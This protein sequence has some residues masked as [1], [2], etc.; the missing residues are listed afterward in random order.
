[1]LSRARIA[2]LACFFL[3]AAVALLAMVDRGRAGEPATRLAAVD[4]AS[5]TEFIVT[6]P[7]AGSALHR[8]DRVA[9]DDPG[10]LAAY[11]MHSLAAGARLE[12][13]RVVPPL[14][15]KIDIPVVAKPRPSYAPV[16]YII[17]PLFLGIAALIAARGRSNGSLSLAW[18][19]ALIVLLFNPTT[20]A[21]PVRRVLQALTSLAFA[22]GD[23]SWRLK[24]TLWASMA[25]RLCEC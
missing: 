3:I 25:S 8:G 16:V 1:M 7:A 19:L 10:E 13:R 23:L 2:T 22:A 24:K 11:E 15:G 14:E 5:P 17:E 12:V 18:L 4:A 21:W 20:P 6:E 9:I